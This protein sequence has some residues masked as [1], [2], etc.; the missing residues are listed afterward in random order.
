[1]SECGDE[2]LDSLLFLWKYGR[3]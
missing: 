1:M 3:D 2:R